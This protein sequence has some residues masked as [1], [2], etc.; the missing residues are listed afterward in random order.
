MTEGIE[1]SCYTCTVFADP[2]AREINLATRSFTM[3][4]GRLVR[5]GAVLTV[6]AVFAAV[7]GCVTGVEDMTFDA[8]QP[9]DWVLRS[10]FNSYSIVRYDAGYRIQLL[11]RVPGSKIGTNVITCNEIGEYKMISENIPRKLHA[12]DRIEHDT[13]LFVRWT[14]PTLI[15]QHTGSEGCRWSGLQHHIYRITS[16]QC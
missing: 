9:H 13:V 6:S 14:I 16:L 4:P 3:M 8:N 2:T 15:Y 12:L 1:E 7:F 5:Q 11:R 10:S